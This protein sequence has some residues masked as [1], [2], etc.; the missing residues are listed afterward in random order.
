MRSCAIQAG[1][2]AEAVYADMLSLGYEL[3]EPYDFE[4]VPAVL[5]QLDWDA[6]VED[7]QFNGQPYKPDID[8]LGT[9]VEHL[10]H[11]PDPRIRWMAQ[12][13]HECKKQWQYEGLL[14]DHPEATEAAF[15]EGETPAG[16][17]KALGE[18]YDLLPAM[19]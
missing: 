16:F 9:A 14:A 5:Q 15:N 8:A 1:G 13:R 4:M 10:F 18:K 6:L 17:V 3:S 7:N 11:K 19:I 12:A 2:I